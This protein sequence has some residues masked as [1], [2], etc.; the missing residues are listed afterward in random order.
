M[1][2]PVRLIRRTF[3]VASAAVAGAVL[4]AAQNPPSSSQTP[5]PQ[6]TPVFRGGVNLITV[7]A[8]PQRNGK[9]VPDL[10]ADDF[11]VLEDGKPQKV[12]TFNFVRIEPG[13]DGT[14]PREPN[15]VREANAMAADP[16][17]RVFVLYLDVYH[18]TLAGSHDVRKPLA[19]L[20]DKLLAPTDLFGMMTPFLRTSDLTLG[21][22]TTSIEDQLIKDW[23]WGQRDSILKGPEDDRLQ[24]CFS[25]VPKTGQPWL[26][27]DGAAE[28][29]L[30]DV[31]IARRREDATIAHLE[32]LMSYLGALREAR[33]AVLLLSPGWVLYQRDDSILGQIVQ[34]PIAS[35]PGFQ[36]CMQAAQTLLSIDDE[37]EERQLLSLANRNNVTFYPVSPNGLQAFD[38]PIN[39]T[40]GST[41]AG[42]VS[43]QELNLTRARSSTAR[44][45]AENTDGIAVVDTND[46]RAGLQRIVD[47]VSA[48]YLLG[49]YS[50][51]PKTDGKYRKIEVKVKRSGISV[52][53]RRGY[54]AP[55][56]ETA[57]AA[58]ASAAHAASGPSPVDG[59]LATLS[60]L[61][62][63]PEILTYGVASAT[64]LSVVVELSGTAVGRS[65]WAQGGDV[66]ATVTDAS[67]AN[68]GTMT[69]R[70]EPA[71]RSVRLHTPLGFGAGPWHVFVRVANRDDSREEK[72][73]IKPPAGAVLGD[74]VVFRGTPAAQSALRP[75]ADFEFRR[76]ERVHIEFPIVT[77]LD[78]RTGRLLDR[79]GQ[80]LPLDVTLTERPATSGTVLAADVNLGPLAPA[81]YLIEITAAHGADSE[82]RL[83]AIRLI[84]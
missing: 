11:E 6:Q 10:T 45:L 78:T 16:A 1:H 42:S 53:A 66:Q 65:S 21:R 61:D 62:K 63:E 38:T 83:V 23:P 8:Y 68:V 15:T 69:G 39:E 32:R 12:E 20:L 24:A 82:R 79:K 84:Q 58:A 41:G 7:D 43:L 9:V 76:S 56:A 55:S 51:N 33:K 52:K 75:V 81:D 26:V 64:D 2:V 71:S 46:L 17:N 28:R 14:E 22:R 70:L 3:A 34:M 73:D 31:L 5:S 67:G 44:T 77:T 60:R 27:K 37:Q 48:Y 49:Y 13:P 47:D 36:P 54:V 29:L 74:P 35:Q 4:L 19:D 57:A 30:S 50:T 18:V 25:Q 80:P 72:F 40:L 59:A